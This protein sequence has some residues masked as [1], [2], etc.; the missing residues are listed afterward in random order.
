MNKIQNY[1]GYMIVQP[2]EKNK[3]PFVQGMAGKFLHEGNT[4]EA[5]VLWV[6]WYLDRACGEKWPPYP[7]LL[8]EK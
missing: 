1:R 4:L 3:R 2:V 6:N 8:D 5:C 7:H